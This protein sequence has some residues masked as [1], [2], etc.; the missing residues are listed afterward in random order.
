MAEE[1][2]LDNKKLESLEGILKKKFGE[3][4]Y[5]IKGNHKLESTKWMSTGFYALD[6]VL[7]KGLPLGKLLQI[8]GWESCGSY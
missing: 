7:G 3:N 2:V 1:Q 4:Y 6:Y 5:G 8:T